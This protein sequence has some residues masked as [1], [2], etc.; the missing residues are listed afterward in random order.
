MAAFA[1]LERDVILG[2]TMVGLAAAKAQGRTGGRPTVMDAD[3]LA[4][5]SARRGPCQDRQGPQ[6]GRAP[7]YPPSGRRGR[8]K[9]GLVRFS[10]SERSPQAGASRSLT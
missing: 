10:I 4:A 1:G 6:R 5:A 7:V 9:P 8:V 3:K 2:R